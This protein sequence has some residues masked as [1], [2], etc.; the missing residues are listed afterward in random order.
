MT[1]KDGQARHIHLVNH[2]L[3]HLFTIFG[4][5]HIVSFTLVISL[6]FVTLCKQELPHGFTNWI[7]THT[8]LLG[9]VL[10]L[11]DEKVDSV[12]IERIM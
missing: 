1:V 8:F 4:Y 5:A 7:G 10:L 9:H 11:K 3:S 2:S 12:K 6:L